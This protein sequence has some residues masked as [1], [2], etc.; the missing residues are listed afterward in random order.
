MYAEINVLANQRA[1]ISIGYFSILSHVEKIY[2]QRRVVTFSDV[3]VESIL[4]YA[5]YFDVKIIILQFDETSDISEGISRIKKYIFTPIIVVYPCQFNGFSSAQMSTLLH[6]NI[7][8]V[9]NKAAALELTHDFLINES[10]FH[11]IV[12]K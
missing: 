8:F 4:K 7:T 10:T 2:T 5:E 1:I 6:K 11:P 12:D 3:R 9:S